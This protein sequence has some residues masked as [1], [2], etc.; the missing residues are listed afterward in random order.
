M[1]NKLKIAFYILHFTFLIFLLLSCTKPNPQ[2]PFDP[3]V[4]ISVSN[5]QYE[6]LVINKIKLTWG[7]EITIDTGIIR[8]DKNAGNATWQNGIAELASDVVTWTD[9]DA[10]INQDLIYRISVFSSEN[11][12]EYD[13]TESINNSIPVPENFNYYPYCDKITLN[14]DYNM[15]G[16]EGFNIARKVG[17]NSWNESY[18]TIAANMLEWSDTGLYTE[19]YQYKVRAYYNSYNSQYSN[20]ITYLYIQDFIPIANI[21]E[22][23][24]MYNGQIIIIQGTV[25]IGTGIINNNQL[26]V[27]IQDNSGKGIMLFD[28]N[29]QPAYQTDLIRGNLILVSGEV[30][31]YNGTTEIKDFTYNI[32]NT[33]NSDPDATI[34]DLGI[35]NNIFEGTFVQATGTIYEKY[36]AGGGTS[37]IIEDENENQL[38]VR[39]W[40]STGI[41]LDEY[42]VGDVLE[43][44]G[45]GGMYNGA[46]QI[47]AGYE[48]HLCKVE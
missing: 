25:T 36:Y 40:D 48:D 42:V 9:N 38:T 4:D 33:G 23:I 34:L 7:N 28:Y 30:N 3:Q 11:Q 14:W 22:N 2:N 32:I 35:N 31:E 13:E 27:F 8:I 46:L 5:L 45:A 18:A 47:L 6:K 29:I 44:C 24:N 17:S 16:I 43:A 10:E 20:E 41:N 26:N 19:T 37:F 15:P 1:R 12:S 21:Q 39:V